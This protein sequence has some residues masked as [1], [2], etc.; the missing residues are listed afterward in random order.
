MQGLAS[1]NKI[2]N[3]VPSG[4]RGERTTFGCAPDPDTAAE[5]RIDRRWRS[6]VI[7]FL[8]SELV[9][10]KTLPSFEAVL[11][12]TMR[13]RDRILPDLLL[14]FVSILLLSITFIKVNC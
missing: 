7:E 6:L 10:E 9:S 14:A 12:R 3:S 1:V 2:H 11:E 5:S 8:R 13:W 4:L